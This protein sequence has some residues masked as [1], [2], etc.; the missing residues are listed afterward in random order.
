MTSRGAHACIR[1]TQNRTTAC[2]WVN[3]LMMP[4]SKLLWKSYDRQQWPTVSCNHKRT[5]S[6]ATAESDM[7][8]VN[9]KEKMKKRAKEETTPMPRIYYGAWQEV[10]QSESREAIT[11]VLRLPSD[12]WSLSAT[13]INARS[14][15]SPPMFCWLLELW[16]RVVQ[17]SQLHA[18]RTLSKLPKAFINW[19]SR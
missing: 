16:W 9:V 17:N 7:V 13:G 8:M 11:P 3:V 1:Y 15:A 19:V 2:R 10:A 4:R 12:Q 6:P 14:F 5:Q 18:P